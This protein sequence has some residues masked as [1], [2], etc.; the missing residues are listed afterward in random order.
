M[1]IINLQACQGVKPVIFNKAHPSGRLRG[2]IVFFVSFS[3][4]RAVLDAVHMNK[5]GKGI[6][7]NFYCLFLLQVIQPILKGE[8]MKHE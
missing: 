6:F 2:F 5:Y 4:E 3:L 7:I 1:L 8:G